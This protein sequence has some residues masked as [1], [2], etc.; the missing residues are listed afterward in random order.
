MRRELF[1]PIEPY[2][3]GRLAV[4]EPHHLYWE[5]SGNPDGIPVLFLHGGP[6]A[7]SSPEHRRMFHPERYRIV[8]FDQRGS[9]RS[10]PLGELRD[11]NTANLIADIERLREHLAVERWLVFGGSWGSTL[12]LAYAEHHPGRCLGLILRGIFLGRALEGDWF[13]HGMR[14]IFP[15]AWRRFVEFLPEG[16]RRDLL[17]SYY[18]RL[19]DPEPSVHG[20]A[21][22]SWAAYEGACSTL[23]ANA[24]VSAAFTREPTAL[25]LARIEAHYFAN[26]FFFTD[27]E[28]L[29]NLG[30]VRNIPTVVVQ[31]RY[32]V[33][34]PIRT[35][36]DLVRAWPPSDPGA[37]LEYIIVPDAG[38]A[39]SEPGI[40]AAL[41]GA[42]ERFTGS[43]FI[44][45][46]A[47]D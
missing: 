41:V 28:L 29:A 7:G 43:R 27:D 38:H 33:V 39:A 19:I 36:D 17:V 40:R 24:A 4:G 8:V 35:A 9:G 22:R 21:A 18:R 2:A 3:T 42:T 11:N 45:M 13:L 31:G 12:G 37:G 6:G 20:P 44:P 26:R 15:E 5:T 16:E 25:G 47:R 23:L 14:A 30:A 46:G 1:P 34:C 10:T 32:D